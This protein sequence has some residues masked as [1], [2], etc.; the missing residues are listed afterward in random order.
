MMKNIEEFLGRK[1]REK[2]I[3]SR[4][5][6]IRWNQEPAETGEHHFDDQKGM[7]NFFI[8]YRNPKI[9]L[10]KILEQFQEGEFHPVLEQVEKLEGDIPKTVNQYLFVSYLS[11]RFLDRLN[12]DFTELPVVKDSNLTNKYLKRGNVEKYIQ[13]F[14]DE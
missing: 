1:G 9:I 4:V 13:K 14:I 3:S 11:N 8:I 7:Y 12:F 10:N 6:Q 2:F 5:P